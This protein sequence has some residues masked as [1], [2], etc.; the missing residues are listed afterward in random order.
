M[1]IQKVKP[2]A[3]KVEVFLRFVPVA[4]AGG[5]PVTLIVQM[6]EMLS[7]LSKKYGIPVRRIGVEGE[8]IEFVNEEITG[9]IYPLDRKITSADSIQEIYRNTCETT[10]EE[11]QYFYAKG[12]RHFVGLYNGYTSYG[13]FALKRAMK[14]IN[15]TN[16]GDP[17]TG[18]VIIQDSSF[19]DTEALSTDLDSGG[20][21]VTRF[22]KDAYQST[23]HLSV[24]FIVNAT[25]P[26]DMTLSRRIP[27]GCL[28]MATSLTY[29]PRYIEVWKQRGNTQKS[30]ARSRLK[31]ILPGWSLITPT[32]RVISLLSSDIWDPSY[33][34]KWMTAEEY[35]TVVRGTT[36]IVKSL[37]HLSD[38]TNRPIF[39]TM[40]RKGVDWILSQGFAR[41]VSAEKVKTPVSSG[42]VVVPYD[43][44]E[45]SNFIDLITGSDLLINRAA[46]TNAFTETIIAGKPQ[47]VLT[48]P[49]LGYMDAELMAKSME[50]GIL[51]YDQNPIE[52]GNEIYKILTDSEY[53]EQLISHLSALLNSMYSNPDTNFWDVVHRIAGLSRKEE[54]LS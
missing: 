31:N 5:G 25:I 45:Q 52:M 7:A 15:E 22:H 36:A 6:D 41:V 16:S 37:L 53:Q 20:Y 24:I 26:F 12:I 13:L 2:I 4:L 43:V 34:G 18:N 21:P 35:A 11:L 33:I 9:K 23:P 40:V 17:I 14:R 51:K 32:D 47:V 10:I 49:A 28:P 3:K 19:P 29:T 1:N 42:L 50:M 38:R 44:L 46:H 39:L 54:Y 48:M 27:S 8:R 30:E